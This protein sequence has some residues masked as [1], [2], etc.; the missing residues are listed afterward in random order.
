MKDIK[1]V[2]FTANDVDG[3]YLLGV[4]TSAGLDGLAE[5]IKRLKKIGMMPNQ[6]ITLL[7]SQNH[8]TTRDLDEIDKANE[9]K[10]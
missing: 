1:E 5:E 8:V 3:V 10:Y 4:F 6:L 7:K 9:E 2:T